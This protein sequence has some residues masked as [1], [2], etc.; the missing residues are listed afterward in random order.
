MLTTNE[1]AEQMGVAYTT[2]MLWLREGKLPGAVKREHPRG[3][4]WEIPASDLKSLDRGRRGRPSKPE[5][6]NG[7]ATKPARKRKKTK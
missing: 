1:V 4:Y 6:A 7:Q 5:A 3:D 2:V